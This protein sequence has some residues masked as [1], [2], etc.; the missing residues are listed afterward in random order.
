MTAAAIMDFKNFKFSRSERSR[1]SQCSTVPNFVKIGQTAVEIWL[2]LNFSI[3]RTPP[4]WI[5]EISFNGGDGQECRTTRPCQISSK[6]LETRPRYCDLLIF[7]DGGRRHLGFWK[8]EIL[9]GRGGLEGRTASLC[10]ISSKSVKP[11]SK[12]GYFEI[13]QYGG[14]RHLGF[15]KY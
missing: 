8:F 13:F 12:Y 1:G 11:R 5:F 15:S 7:Q 2:F 4:S 9:N 6:L 14:R 3:W 10:Q